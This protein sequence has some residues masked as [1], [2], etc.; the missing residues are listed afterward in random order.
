MG[1]GDMGT[2]FGMSHWSTCAG[3]PLGG[4]AGIYS[5]PGVSWGIAG[6]VPP[7]FRGVA[8]APW[9]VEGSPSRPLGCSDLGWHQ[10]RA[11]VA[12]P[13]YQGGEARLLCGVYSLPRF[14][15]SSKGCSDFN[16]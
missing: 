9:D 8:G 7:H 15:P 1:R 5:P 2:C 16:I 12:S 10:S 3:L 11:E 14:F 13:C 6:G 4:V